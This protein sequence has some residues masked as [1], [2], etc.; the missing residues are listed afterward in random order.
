MEDSVVRLWNIIRDAVVALGWVK[1]SFTLFFWAAHYWIY[2]TY[3]GRL[4]DRQQEIDRLAADNHEYRDRFLAVLDKHLGLPPKVD[5]P[6][7]LPK[8]DDTE[9]KK[10]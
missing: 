1:G 6:K 3:K 4:E 7:E 5:I 9:N 2:T 10:E 8:P